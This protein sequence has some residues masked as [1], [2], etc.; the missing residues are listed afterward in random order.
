MSEV[1]EKPYNAADEH[2]LTRGPAAVWDYLARPLAEHI[3]IPLEQR[4]HNMAVVALN[5]TLTAPRLLKPLIGNR[6]SQHVESGQSWAAVGDV[7]LSTAFDATDGL[8]GATVRRS[9][10]GSSF[11]IGFDSFVDAASLRDDIKRVREQAIIKEDATVLRLLRLDGRIKQGTIAL[12]GVANKASEVYVERCKGVELE[13]HEK[14]H[15]GPF[16][17]AY[18]LAGA[19]ATKALQIAYAFPDDTATRKYW[20]RA[21]I[22]IQTTAIG[23]GVAANGQYVGNII[24]RLRKPA[25][26]S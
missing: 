26:I 15:S 12:G 21:G 11:G 14:A 13:P 7:A 17:K 16:G 18:F 8:D 10:L 5:A 9:N 22:G 1:L 25:E 6:Y 2:A 20:R 23:L 3:F 19:V 24:K 4:N